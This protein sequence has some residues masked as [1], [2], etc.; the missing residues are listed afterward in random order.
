MLE[1]HGKWLEVVGESVFFEDQIERGGVRL[2]YS[3]EA[4][5]TNTMT[6]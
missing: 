1:N 5:P 6:S 4:E 3:R 2:D